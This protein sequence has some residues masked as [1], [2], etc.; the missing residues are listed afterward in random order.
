MVNRQSGSSVWAVARTS[1]A[2][3]VLGGALLAPCP[4]LAQQLPTGGTVTHGTATVGPA[5]GGTLNINQT[6]NRAIIDWNSFSVGAGGRVNF[7]QPG[8]SAATLNR[9]TGTTSSTI[10]GAITAPGTVL[11]VNPNGIAITP[12]GTVNVGSFAASTL[13]IKNSDFLAGNYKFTGNGSSATV[14]NAGRIN[15]SD[16]GFAALL[17]GRVANDGI[18]TARLGRVGLGSGEKITLDLAGD[19]FLQV[20]V[21][22]NQLGNLVDG[23][24]QA[25][26]SNRGKIRV[27]GGIVHLSA[28]TANAILRDA[29]NVPGSIRANSVGTRGGRIVLGGGAGGRVTVSGRLSASGVRVARRHQPGAGGQI[30]IAGA[31]IALTAARLDASGATGGGRIRIGG[32]YQGSGDFQHAQRVSIDSAS[33]IRADATQGGNGGTII[34]WSDGLT[35]VAGE[36]SARGGANGGNGGLVET[37]G[38]ELSFNGVRVDTSARRGRTGE[39][40]LDPENLAIDTAAAATISANLANS[41]V[42]LLTTATTAS[43]PGVR[44]AGA[45]DIIIYAPI[46][47]TSGN[48]LSLNAYNS[49]YIN[50]AIFGSGVGSTLWLRTG[51]AGVVAQTAPISV[52]NL[53][54]PLNFSSVNLTNP[55]NVVGY[56]WT[57]D[58]SIDPNSDFNVVNPGAVAFTNNGSLIT[59]TLYARGLTLNVGGQLTGSGPISSPNGAVTILAPG[60]INL[61]RGITGQTVSVTSSAG[62]VSLAGLGSGGN[63]T[64]RANGSITFS[65]I[66][67]VQDGVSNALITLRADNGAV[68]F[69]SGH[70]S[71]SSAVEIFY[72]PY[73]GTGSYAGSVDYSNLTSGFGNG[74]VSAWMLI[75]NVNQLQAIG[76]NYAGRYA[77]GNDIDAS[78]TAG[79]N[80]NAGCAGFAPI[81]NSITGLSVPVGT[82]TGLLD[83]RGFAIL[84]MYQD[85]NGAFGGSLRDAGLFQT[86]AGTVRNLGFIGGTFTGS[87]LAG[88]VAATN[89]GLISGVYSTANVTVGN[90]T[91]GGLVGLNQTTGQITGGSYA[92]GRVWGS[93]QGTVGTAGGLVGENRGN[94]N[95]S[96]AAGAVS[97]STAGGLVGFNTGGGRIIYTY[98]LSTVN[99]TGY[100]GGLVGLNQWAGAGANNWGSIEQSYAAGRLTGSTIGGL[101]GKNE[102]NDTDTMESFNAQNSMSARVYYS[103]WDQAATGASQAFGFSYLSRS[104]WSSNQVQY[105]AALNTP[106]GLS[107]YSILSYGFFRSPQVGNGNTEDSG[108]NDHW[109][110]VEGQTRPF[111][112]A[113]FSTNIQNLHQLQLVN[114]NGAANYR[115]TRNIDASAELASGMW[116]NNSFSPIRPITWTDTVTPLYASNGN[117][118]Q[119]QYGLLRE[120][121]PTAS[122]FTGSLDGQGFTISNLRVDRTLSYSIPY[123]DDPNNFLY[124]AWGGN[125]PWRSIVGPG[126]NAGLFDTI[127]WGGSVRNLGIVNGQFITSS[128]TAGSIAGTNNGTIERS[129]AERGAGTVGWNVISDNLGGGLVG[130]NNGLI[131]QSYASVNVWGVGQ[132]WV[133][134]QFYAQLGGL[135]GQ[136]NGTIQNA[137][138]TGAVYGNGFVGGLVGVNTGNISN[139]YTATYLDRAYDGYG[140]R[141]AGRLVGN[142]SGTVSNSYYNSG[143][144]LPYATGWEGTAGTGLTTAQ[145]QDINTFRTVYAGWDFQNVW[146][147]PNQAGQAGQSTAHYPEFYFR[148][149][150]VV[151]QAADSTRAY[152]DANPAFLYSAYGLRSYDTPNVIGAAVST[153]A[154]QTSNVTTNGQSYALNANLT[155]SATSTDG[156]TYRVINLAGALTISAR[157][158]TVTANDQSKTYGDQLALQSSAFTASGLAN[159]ETVGTV[160]LAS[161]GAASSANAGTYSI[162]ASN[163]AGGTF[164]ASNYNIT[165]VSGTLN[166]TRANLTITANNRTSTYGDGTTF[167]GSEFTTSGLR[168]SQTVG[169]VT[170]TS[171]GA[172]QTAAASTT[173]YAIVASNATGG[174]FNASNYNITYGNGGLTVNRA[175]L[176]VTANNRSSV[177]GDGTAFTGTEFTS[178]GLRNNETI[179]SVSLSSAGASQTASVA[180]SPYTIV[181]SNATGGTFNANNYN[182]TY[183]NGDL[184]VNRADLTVR[185]NNVTAV[186][187]RGTTFNGNEFSSTGLRNGETIGSVSLTSAGA[188]QTASVAGGPYAI[189][190]S[191]A[192]GGTFNANNYNIAYA[193]GSLTITRAP[194]TVTANDLRAVYGQ[195]TT[196]AGDEFTSAGLQNG[197]TIGRVSLTSTGASRTASVA[198]GPYAIVPSNASGGTFDAN[199]YNITYTNG[200][201]TITRA[202]LTVTAND[203]SS[204]YGQGTTFAGDEFRS[205]GL[206]NGE[207][208]GRV[209]LTSAGAAR[210]ASVAG[211]PYAIVANN[212]SGGTFDANNY[213]ISYGNGWLSV[214]PAT[215]SVA[216]NG[217]VSTYGASPFN[218]GI[219]V[220]GLQNGEDVSVLGGLTNSFGI[221][222]RTNA[223]RYT[224]NVDGDLT[225]SNYVIKDRN[226]GTWTVDPAAITVMANGG[227]SI[228]G[229]SPL[230][231]GLSATGLQNG[232]GI[233][234]LTGLTNSFGI[235]SRTGAGSYAT[236]VVGTLT[237]GNYTITSRNEG[238][239][240]VNPA[241]ITV[242]ANGGRSIYGQSPTNPGFGAIGL[243]NGEGVDVLT[244][245]TNSFGIT[246]RTNAGQYALNVAGQLT[247]PNY[248]VAGRVAGLWI[249]D[250][251]ALTVAANP[252]SRLV[253]ELDPLLTYRITSGQLFNGDGF[254]GELSRERGDAPGN[255][256]ITQ[257]S[258]AASANYAL[259]FIGSTFEIRALPSDGPSQGR[260]SG[261]T[262]QGGTTTISFQ[263]SQPGPVTIGT[264]RTSA[265]TAPTTVAN[266]N[267]P[268]SVV[269]GT[270][271]ANQ[272]VLTYLPIS[273][274]EAR[275]YTNSA[276]PGYEDRTGEATVLT[277]IARALAGERANTLFIDN[278]WSTTANNNAGATEFDL[279]AQ[280][281][282]FSNGQGK[283]IDPEKANPFGLQDNDPAK[284]LQ[285]GPLMIVSTAP[286]GQSW[287]LALRLTEDGKGII[288]NDPSTGR[289]VTLAYDPETKAIGGVK[290]VLDPKTNAWIA[291]DNADALKA[292]GLEIAPERVTA[293]QA[294]APTGYLAVG[295]N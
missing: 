106:G 226:T 269:T 206:Q 77:L 144:A 97:G 102:F 214:T 28:A 87:R 275:E 222:N 129:W 193:T 137:Y 276:L 109:Y 182:I 98:S 70:I 290:S 52:Q 212:A 160:S 172:S 17:G 234:V 35:S 4:T 56:L 256:A 105:I 57:D 143:V 202:P 250:R 69:A 117:G 76:T 85:W 16:G 238:V 230:N 58:S 278:F 19:G 141:E 47:W 215:I 41:S 50:A 112:R 257:G 208:I 254:S 180:G 240:A 92:T 295:V 151:L 277:M 2:V 292:A 30:D 224:L 244:G 64:V 139:T 239:W 21:P 223:G 122:S 147:P 6:S 258:L 167:N 95:N 164:N 253:T 23:T 88:S 203:R 60:N 100:T 210:T 44:S 235:T 110:I 55:G 285:S 153:T 33:V 38:H 74:S 3:F 72:N 196:F 125:H 248:V 267:P 281:V 54:L 219:S 154:T 287:M 149:H 5:Q 272:R 198:G 22:S 32:D 10:A 43:G 205:S 101:V 166:V 84:N 159:G 25:L 156:A 113:E 232:E 179:G 229:Q 120:P 140:V 279:I 274:F 24:G 184:T 237:N 61:A 83:G 63:V 138:A 135:V 197:E 227:R 165:Y 264:P 51:A 146:I 186:Y 162:S 42:T 282:T 246:G 163:A 65:D 20:E 86:N 228:Y 174:T 155:R 175:N 13:D 245:L 40:L 107:P 284:L 291:I 99:G 192:T 220:I 268:D 283:T 194:V 242:T 96:Y 89:T 216:A 148:N 266:V 243:Q 265:P 251:A 270:L 26:V 207:T 191:N 31:E 11:L 199:N 262:T 126:A 118:G 80:C 178:S 49:I 114:M 29:V 236:R 289:Q 200:S 82:F 46:Y 213:T 169:S 181:A 271:N 59:G 247:N 36:F 131:S 119:I 161:S 241:A 48:T 133:D 204:V 128:G 188:S 7:N 81:G 263:P 78:A 273:Q 103:Y 233:D 288:A 124:Q 79:W 37:S 93:G 9:V 286:N 185:A 62:S 209:D 261:P 121:T 293:L 27:D 127:A 225:N 255:Y 249:V 1:S 132:S 190:A 142:N 94:V 8:A 45:G 136:N 130:Q 231:P 195:G 177:Y 123:L 134:Y 68:R 158:L 201:L 39:W 14:T 67:F 176:T 53:I 12:T 168:N 18:I 260:P 280:R 211:G 90:G 183:A 170:L 157:A 91:A 173:P 218:P 75:N 71:T 15:V 221:T 187:G 34:V 252:Q 217:G 116:R 73:V 66:L 150:V 111:L 171:T 189:V 115:L 104:G 294:F 259:S 108:F 145:M 152:G